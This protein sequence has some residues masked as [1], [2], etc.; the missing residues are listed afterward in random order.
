M[1]KINVR[2]IRDILR[3][4]WPA[5]PATDIRLLPPCSRTLIFCFLHALKIPFHLLVRSSPITA[6]VVVSLHVPSSACRHRPPS[7]SCPLPFTNYS[8]SLPC[9]FLPTSNP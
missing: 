9:F 8:T 1:S 2:R 3:L 6:S 7:Q 4:A 5:A